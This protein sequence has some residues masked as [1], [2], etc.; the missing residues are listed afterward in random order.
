MAAYSFTDEEASADLLPV[1]DRAP[2]TR[3]ASLL[4]LGVLAGLLVLAVAAGR[5]ST[6]GHSFLEASISDHD[7]H[8][9]QQIQ[10]ELDQTLGDL[11]VDTSEKGFSIQNPDP[12]LLQWDTKADTVAEGVPISYFDGWLS[13]PLVHDEHL[14]DFEASP[15]VCLRVQAVVAQA[16]NASGKAAP[17]GVL[18]THGGGPGSDRT[19]AAGFSRW[20]TMK[21]ERLLDTFDSISMNQRGVFMGETIQGLKECNFGKVIQP[22]DCDDLQQRYKENPEHF[23]AYVSEHAGI[24]TAAEIDIATKIIKGDMDKYDPTESGFAF[25]DETFVRVNYRLKKLGL[26][27]CF[28]HPRFS[29]VGSNGR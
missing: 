16:R 28:N 22:L 14:T 25:M 9:L 11:G 19:V 12:E 21:G 8:L 3:R 7:V 1:E 13:V 2:Q 24:T 4:G 20:K 18:F 27:L 5:D 10:D 23:A 17:Q 26:N 15:R 29:L 6:T